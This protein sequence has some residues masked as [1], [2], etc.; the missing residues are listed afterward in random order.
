[1]TRRLWHENHCALVC[2]GAE[3]DAPRNRASAS[4]GEGTG[5]PEAACPSL[6]V[7]SVKYRA[8]AIARPGDIYWRGRVIF[9][10]GRC[11]VT[12]RRRV[13]RMKASPMSP[14]GRRH[15]VAAAGR[16]RGRLCHANR[17]AARSKIEAAWAIARQAFTTRGSYIKLTCR[18]WKLRRN[19]FRLFQ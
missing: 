15:A 10:L 4:L 14:A 3:V 8:R 16:S 13:E 19:R 18:A 5:V 12:G 11:I 1:M 17:A 6:A 9:F 2:A 7:S